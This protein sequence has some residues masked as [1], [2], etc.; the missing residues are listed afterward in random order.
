MNGDATDKQRQNGTA[1][2]AGSGRFEIK[3]C[4][5]LVTG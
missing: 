4:P 5:E 2:G 1:A 3:D